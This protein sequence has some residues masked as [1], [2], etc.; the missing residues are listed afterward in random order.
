MSGGIVGRDFKRF[1][2]TTPSSVGR[3]GINR[4]IPDLPTDD[5][6]VRRHHLTC[7]VAELQHSCKGLWKPPR[8]GRNFLFVEESLNN[9]NNNNNNND[10]Q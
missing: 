9:S 2:R 1:R 4:S 5:G 10:F 7:T 6:V 3:S 8:S